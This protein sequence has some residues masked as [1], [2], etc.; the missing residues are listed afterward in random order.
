MAK[1][2][3][4]KVINETLRIGVVPVFYHPDLEVAK[5]VV[6][7]CARAGLRLIEFTN[8]GDNA[9]RIFSDLVLHFTSADPGVIL[10]AGSGIEAGTVPCI[11]QAEPIS[12]SV[13]C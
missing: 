10:G 6:Q 12:W 1:I 11:F 13:R 4:V 3:R 5:K 2:S 9:W 7:A 8:R